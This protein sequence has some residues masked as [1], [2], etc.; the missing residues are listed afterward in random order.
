MVDQTVVNGSGTAREPGTGNGSDSAQGEGVGKFV[1]D[2]A[3]LAELQAKLAAID[4]RDAART[5]AVPLVL[6]MGGLA[7]LLAGLPVALLGGGWLLAWA[8]KIEPGWGML[9]TAG[10]AIALGALVAG[11]AGMRLRHCFDSFRR[12][13]EQLRIN[14][15]WVRSVLV[16][17]TGDRKHPWHPN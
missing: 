9:L 17:T 14:L 3:S 5:A 16:T 15:A 4:F 7:L 6:T 10:P 12:S 2:L 8:L 13:H 11:L 1:D